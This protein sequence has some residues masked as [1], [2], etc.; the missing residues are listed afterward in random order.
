MQCEQMPQAPAVT[1]PV[2]MGLS[3]SNRRLAPSR[4][5]TRVSNVA[6]NFPLG[7]HERSGRHYRKSGRALTF[8]AAQA[9]GGNSESDPVRLGLDGVKSVLAVD[10]PERLSRSTGRRKWVC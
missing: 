4:R 7:T 2:V 8:E 1:R 5:D 10:Y 3:P 6:E 9:Q